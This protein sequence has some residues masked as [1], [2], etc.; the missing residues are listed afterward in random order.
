M[1]VV[2]NTIQHCTVNSS[3]SNQTRKRNEK[4]P[5]WKEKVKI[6]LLTDNMILYIENLKNSQKNC[7]SQQ[8]NS[9]KLQDTRATYI[10][11]EYP[12]M[13]TK[14]TIPYIIASKRIKYLVIILTKEG[15]DFTLKTI[16]HCW[17]KLMKT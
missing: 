11:S 16:N 6:S 3:Q 8:A 9:A 15:K 2:T 12:K 7:Q 10:V 14:E 1:F 4:H 13:E 17:N 5:N